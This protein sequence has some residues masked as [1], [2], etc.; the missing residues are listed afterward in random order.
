MKFRATVALIILIVSFSITGP[1]GAQTAPAVTEPAPDVV[2]PVTPEAAAPAP[3]APSPAP[4]RS[5]PAPAA[6][7]LNEVDVWRVASALEPSEQA[8]FGFGAQI[9]FY[10]PN[11]LSVRAGSR[12]ISLEVS[13]GFVPV[14]LS[15]GDSRSP[16]LKLLFPFEVTPQLVIH[17]TTFRHGITAAALLGYRYNMALGHGATLGGQI[18][19]RIAPKLVV[20]GMLGFSYYPDAANRL[21]GDQVPE[22]T[23]F[24]FPPQLG[25]GI[26]VG[27]LIYP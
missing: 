19:K 3:A 25:E 9:G 15:Y 12:T 16:D 14:L 4:E 5:S 8:N 6:P 27:L 11:G 22:G 17:A 26:T 2:A 23:T 20:E 10:N 24:N 13:A 21:R 7:S 18:E 1:V